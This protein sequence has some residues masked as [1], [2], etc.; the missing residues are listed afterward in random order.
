MSIDLMSE[1]TSSIV[2]I[3]VVLMLKILVWRRYRASVR[4]QRALQDSLA[5]QQTHDPNYALT[6]ELDRIEAR[7]QMLRAQRD[8]LLEQRAGYADLSF[9]NRQKLLHAMDQLHVDFNNIDRELD[10]FLSNLPNTT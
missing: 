5:R 4:S 2:F 1:I 3:T 10:A 7:L 9:P 6:Q 8:Q